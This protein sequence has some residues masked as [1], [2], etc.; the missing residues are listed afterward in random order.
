MHLKVFISRNFNFFLLEDL[1]LNSQV[2]LLKS[3]IFKYIKKSYLRVWDLYLK[4]SYLEDWRLRSQRF[5]VDLKSQIFLPKDLRSSSTSIFFHSK[6]LRLKSHMLPLK[7]FNI[8]ISTFSAKG[9]EIFILNFPIQGCDFRIH[10]FL[11]KGLR[12]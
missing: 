2:F 8:F 6:D 10:F 12:S 7:D 1:K 3:L 11:L 5:L 4:L 9:F